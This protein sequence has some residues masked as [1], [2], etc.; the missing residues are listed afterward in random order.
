MTASTAD[1]APVGRRARKQELTRQ[2]LVAAAH[3]QMSAAGAQSITILSITEQADVAQGTFYNYFDSRDALID[4]VIHE[5]VETFG[6]R[7]DTLTRDMG[8]AAEIYSFSLRHL[9]HTAVSDPVWGWLLVRLGIAQ[10]T[11]L[12]ILGPRAAR[13]IQ[14]GVD[15]GRFVVPDVALASAM[16]FGAMLSAMHSYLDGTREF[17]PSQQ[18]AEYLLRMVGIPSAEAHEITQRPL[19]PMP[20]LD[21]LASENQSATPSAAAG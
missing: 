4:V 15:S 12:S 2:R 7:L 6:Q 8:D 9:M 19:P 14:I 3:Q 1:V 11:L 20:A 16:T 10:D 5:A 13:D 17:D 18:Y 21:D